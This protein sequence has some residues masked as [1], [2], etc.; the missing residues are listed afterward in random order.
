MAEQRF[1][2]YGDKTMPVPDGMTLEQL[3]TQ[4]ARFFPELAEPKV[5]SKKDEAKGTTTYVFSKQAGKKG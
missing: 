4:M 3:K 2:R 5:E 1:A